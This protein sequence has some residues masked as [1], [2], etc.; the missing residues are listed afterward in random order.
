MSIRFQKPENKFDGS[1]G[2]DHSEFVFNYIDAANEY[3]LD[4]GLKYPYHLFSGETKQYHRQHVEGISTTFSEANAICLKQFN[5]P[6][7]QNRA[8][9]YLN[10]LRV[11]ELAMMENNTVAASLEKI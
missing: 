2:Q 3:N 6:T 11:S 8:K 10:R 5:S 7:R 9:K 1:L 4:D